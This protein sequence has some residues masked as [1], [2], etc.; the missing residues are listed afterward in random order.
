MVRVH[1]TVG[2]YAL[3]WHEMRHF[4]PT[5]ARF[6]P[7]PS[8]ESEPPAS[9]PSVAVLY[10]A[11]DVDTALAEVF[12]HAR[13]IHPAGA[14]NPYLT[15]W[16]PVRPLRLLDVRGQWPLRA[17]ASYALNTGPQ[18]VCRRWA[19]DIA[20]HPQR[21]DGILYA[22]SM[23]GSDAVALFL[24]EADSFP[25]TPDLSMPLSHPGL[26]GVISGVADRIG[27]LVHR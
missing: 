9:H 16:R 19:H 26:V 23:T 8:F 6:D 3:P 20:I 13:V 17:G 15:V 11:A 22:S 1:G 4:G 27:C 18:P 5:R 7:H 2:P 10:A 14:N 21:V 12:Q 24:P 25:A